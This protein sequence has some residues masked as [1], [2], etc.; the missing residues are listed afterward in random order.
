[1]SGFEIAGVALAAF[2]L[3]VNGVNQLVEGA[4]TIHRW[5]KYKLKLKEYAHILESAK[6]HLDN[7]LEALLI[8]IVPTDEELKLLLEEPGGP[9]WSKAEYDGRLR[10]R[11]DRSYNSF[12]RT[13][14]RLIQDTN[15]LRER[16]GI[17]NVGGVHT[18][19]A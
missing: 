4:E 12:L 1:M 3:L 10:K 9:S 6:V 14:E 17:D 11:L 7:T 19:L 2:P 15:A 13:I 5:K 8:D 18:N 16:L